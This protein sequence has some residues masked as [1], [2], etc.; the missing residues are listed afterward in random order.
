MKLYFNF[1]YHASCDN[2]QGARFGGKNLLVPLDAVEGRLEDY[3]VRRDCCWTGC[4][5]CDG[6]HVVSQD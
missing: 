4:C 1:D 6:S 2:Y 3:C 5:S